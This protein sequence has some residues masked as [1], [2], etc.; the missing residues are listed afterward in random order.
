MCIEYHIQINMYH[1]SAQGVERM[2]NVHY[3]YYYY[4]CLRLEDIETTIYFQFDSDT[5]YAACLQLYSQV[6]DLSRS[7]GEKH[8][9]HVENTCCRHMIPDVTQ[10]QRGIALNINRSS[11]EIPDSTVS[12]VG[13]SGRDV[14]LFI[15]LSSRE[16]DRQTDRQTQRD[17]QTERERENYKIILNE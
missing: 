3:Y 8:T 14:Q 16:G 9:R 11:L 5:I 10:E 7:A 15:L 4:Y 1:V 17:R 6:M 13:T 2:I 12:S